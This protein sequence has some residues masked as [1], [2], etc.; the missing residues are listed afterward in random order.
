MQ[1]DRAAVIQAL[2]AADLRF[3]P[4]EL[5]KRMSRRS[6]LRTGEDVRRATDRLTQQLDT[7]GI[8]TLA[9]VAADAEGQD[10]ELRLFARDASKPDVLRFSLQTARACSAQLR[11]LDPQVPVVKPTIGIEAV[12]VM[13]IDGA[14]VTRVDP[15][16]RRPVS[17]RAW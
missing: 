13:R 16:A 11:S 4:V 8:A 12:D 6:R 2:R 10:V 7:Q 14:V 5:P 9:R 17:Y 1:V 15:E 3:V